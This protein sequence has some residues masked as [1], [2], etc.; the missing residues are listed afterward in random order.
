MF[1]EL[2]NHNGDL[3]DLLEKGYA[4]TEDHGYLVVRDIPYL[5]NQARCQTGAIVTSICDVDGKKVK[6][7]DHQI[8]FAGSHPCEMDG[9]PI[10]GLGGGPTNLALTS[11]PDVVV[12]RSFS[13]KLMTKEGALRDYQ[14]F[15][16]KLEH[17]VTIISGPAK[18]KCGATPYTFRLVEETPTNSVFKFRDTLT[19]R[20]QIVDL[21]AKFADDVVA[22]IG[23]GGTGSY[24]LDL[25]VKTPVK[26]I[27]GFDFD[28]FHVHTAYRSPGRLADTNELGK[29]KAEVYRSR[30][31]NFRE[32]LRLE[33]RYIDAQSL[34][35]LRGVTFAFVCVDKGKSRAGIF[36]LLISNKIPFID[37]GMGL[38]RT[39]GPID[40]TLRATYYS[41]EHA[42]RLRDQALA[43]LVD[44]PADEYRIHVQTA[45]LNALNAA[46]A[47]IKFKQIKGFY[48]DQD[49][50]NS[51]AMQV[52]NIKTFHET[53]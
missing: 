20:A 18:E 25:L 2:A 35:S 21:S 17:Y 7:H 51:L 44:D 26:E 34:E 1:L 6:P 43:E 4:I 40:G 49:M 30:Y 38:N 8:F 42:Q 53:L 45:E 23:L 10:K 29:N 36:D 27:R 52:G 31:E 9:T 46:L 48:F 24:V 3:K 37:V 5:D 28:D 11:S 41:V 15:F 19:S 22:V 39:R 50:L 14:D 12:Q 16:E 33:P 32:G 47:V 13:N